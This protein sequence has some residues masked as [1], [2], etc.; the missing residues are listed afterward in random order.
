MHIQEDINSLLTQNEEFKSSVEYE[1]IQV[2][3]K[4]Q[5]LIQCLTHAIFNGKFMR[6]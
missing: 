4:L 6:E 1:G 2:R 5:N 3:A